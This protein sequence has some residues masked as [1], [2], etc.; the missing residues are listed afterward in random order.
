MAHGATG[1]ERWARCQV[2]LW[3]LA[4]LLGHRFNAGSHRIGLSGGV[5]IASGEQRGTCAREVF[6][7][8]AQVTNG[9]SLGYSVERL[10]ASHGKS[11]AFESVSHKSAGSRITTS[12]RKPGD[13]MSFLRMGAAS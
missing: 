12:N 13:A 4:Q 5:P 2:L 11:A 7:G 1:V 9:A 10:G 3:P 6:S 8:F